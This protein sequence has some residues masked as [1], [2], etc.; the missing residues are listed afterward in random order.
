MTA[1][2]FPSVSNYVNT[3]SA[4]AARVIAFGSVSGNGATSGVETGAILLEDGY[5]ILT[6]DG[7][8]ILLES[9]YPSPAWSILLENGTDILL[10]EDG[11]SLILLE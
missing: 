3:T 10:Q 8:L 11:Q 7:A 1:V 4:E 2:S 9:T 5:S 6:E